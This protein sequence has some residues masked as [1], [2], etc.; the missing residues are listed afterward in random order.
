M[1]VR[2]AAVVFHNGDLPSGDPFYVLKYPFGKTGLL[3]IHFS[4]PDF[5]ISK[6]EFR[7]S[8]VP[9]SSFVPVPFLESQLKYAG[10]GVP[11]SKTGYPLGPFQTRIKYGYGYR[12]AKLLPYLPRGAFQVAISFRSAVVYMGLALRYLQVPYIWNAISRLPR[13]RNEVNG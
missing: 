5:Q 7:T 11:S 9:H 1:H 10:P 3:D 8:R 6:S 2:K 13:H 4:K 12:M